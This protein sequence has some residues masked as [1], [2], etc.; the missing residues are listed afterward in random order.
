[1]EMVLLVILEMIDRHPS[2]MNRETPAIWPCLTVCCVLNGPGPDCHREM[3]L[4]FV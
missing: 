4:I 1:M 3:Q 2:A